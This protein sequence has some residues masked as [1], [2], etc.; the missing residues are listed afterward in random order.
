MAN[1]FVFVLV[2]RLKL[3]PDGD[4]DIAPELEKFLTERIQIT[5]SKA[6]ARGRVT[7]TQEASALWKEVYPQLA[8]G[9]PGVMGA[10]CARAEAQ[11]LR[12]AMIF[13]LLDEWSQIDVA[14]LRAALALWD[15]C[16]DCAEYIFG[17]STGDKNADKILEELRESEDGLTRK[18]IY[19]DVFSK[20]KRQAVIEQALE[21]LAASGK[22][23]MEMERDGWG[24]LNIE[25]WRAV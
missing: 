23:A 7:M 16:R 3:L 6:R 21:K 8:E 4:G 12:F 14:H 2:R 25:R 19:E 10:A 17:N 24:R 20:N 15:Y 1:R 5:L 18:Q 22:A 11:T 13:A 9:V